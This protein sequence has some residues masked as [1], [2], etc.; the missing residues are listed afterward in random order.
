MILPQ[1]ISC[2]MRCSRSGPSVLPSSQTYQELGL[3]GENN[4]PFVFAASRSVSPALRDGSFTQRNLAPACASATSRKKAFASQARRLLPHLS[5]LVVEP[6]G[7]FEEGVAVSHA[8]PLS[9]AASG[10]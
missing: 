4:P 7:R 1:A 3:P 5:S 6:R 10:R 8:V 2:A 9:S